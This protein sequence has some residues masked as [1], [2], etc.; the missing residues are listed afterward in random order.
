MLATGA[1]AQDSSAHCYSTDANPYLNFA[2]KT[3]YFEATR[4]NV[5]AAEA[6]EAPAGCEA[7][8]F[9]LVARH[10]TRN[11]GRDKIRTMR[12]NGPKMR[13]RVI[14]MQN[15]SGELCADD[16]DLLRDW[17]FNLSASEH[18]QLADSGKRE[19]RGL[20]QRFRQRF[21]TVLGLAFD[22]EKYYVSGE[23]DVSKS[24]KTH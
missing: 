8:A 18:Y 22:E 6:A 23:L 16:L 2:T 14:R 19:M 12:E 4:S 10:G 7:R 15:E 11:P 3:S 13:R 20:G 5:D 24:Q 9:W 1:T 17:S 21:E